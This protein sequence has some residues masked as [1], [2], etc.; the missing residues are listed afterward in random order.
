MEKRKFQVTNDMLA[1]QGERFFNYVVDFI[2][3]Y[4]LV[5]VLTLVLCFLFY[6]IGKDSWVNRIAE[7]S[8]GEE[9]LVGL[10]ITLIYYAGMESLSGRTIGKYI[11]KTM[12]VNIDGE[13]VTSDI[14]LRRTLCRL[15]PFEG[16]SF[17]GANARGWHD[18]ISDTYV[19]KKS[20]LEQKK[21]MFNDFDE[22]GNGEV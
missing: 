22:I 7:L 11:T 15:I 3:Q 16:F 4:V 17:F 8:K 9:F 12:V 1:T 2:F 19:V 10:L 21:R 5:I 18:T 6:A 13:K 20:L 14:I